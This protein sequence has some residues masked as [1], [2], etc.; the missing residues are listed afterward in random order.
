MDGIGPVNPPEQRPF[1]NPVV[2][3]RQEKER[4]KPRP[5][6]KAD[7]EDESELSEEEKGLDLEA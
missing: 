1:T 5:S 3:P 2:W 6:A 4:A 7:E